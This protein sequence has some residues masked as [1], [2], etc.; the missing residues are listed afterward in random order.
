MQNYP[1]TMSFDLWSMPHRMTVRNA[2]GSTYMQA[3]RSK[4]LKEK[5]EVVTYQNH[6]QQSY[7]VAA[8]ALLSLKPIHSILNQQGQS[9][10][11]IQLNSL[12]RDCQYNIFDGGKLIF[13]VQEETNPRRSTAFLVVVVATFAL[14]AFASQ[15]PL[16]G[17][18]G[19]FPCLIVMIGLYATRTGHFLNPIYTVKRPDGRRVMQFAKIPELN[20]HNSRFSIKSIDRVSSTEEY[21]A[22]FAIM[23][24]ILGRYQD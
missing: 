19:V 22:L 8:D 21:S 5:I 14:A 17:A 6:R 9:I 20:L 16:L 10:S 1:L 13:Q 11:T 18:V 2:E 3:T 24:M 23:L 7:T 4:T 15:M 12:W